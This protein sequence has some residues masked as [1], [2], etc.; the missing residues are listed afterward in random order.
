MFRYDLNVDKYSFLQ[1]ELDFCERLRVA[2]F[3]GQPQDDVGMDRWGL[4][5]DSWY[6]VINQHKR[7]DLSLNSF[8]V[9]ERNKN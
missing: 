5:G 1:E 8:S 3:Q 6:T 2:C 9:Q 4:I 7:S